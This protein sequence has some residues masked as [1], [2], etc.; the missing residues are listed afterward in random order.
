VETEKHFILE[1]EAFK[2]NRESYADMMA[3]RFWDNL[4]SRF[5]EKLGAFILKLHRKRAE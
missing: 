1:C 4:F 5:V 3:V 2:H